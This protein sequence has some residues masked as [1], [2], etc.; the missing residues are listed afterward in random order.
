MTTLDEA[1][2]ANYSDLAAT[3]PIWFSFIWNR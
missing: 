3:S 2:R 1:T